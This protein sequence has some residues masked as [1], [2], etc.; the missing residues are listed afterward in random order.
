RAGGTVERLV[1]GGVPLGMVP[2]FPFGEREVVL[3]PGDM[4]VV[5]TD[6]V[7]EAMRDEEE[8][9]DFRLIETLGRAAA[10]GATVAAIANAIMDAVR[11]WAGRADFDDDVTAVV[12]RVR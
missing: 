11:E 1:Q 5:Y 4:L 7:T 6:G 9:D 8:F 12:L 10:G 3:A 2:G